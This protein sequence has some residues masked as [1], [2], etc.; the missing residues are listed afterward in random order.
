MGIVD[1]QCLVSS[2]RNVIKELCI[3]RV[4]DHASSHWIF[5]SLEV[6]LSPRLQKT[7]KWLTERFHGLPW[8][9]GEVPY[10]VMKP[11]LDAA[12]SC[13][14]FLLVKGV[15]K[16]NTLKYLLPFATIYNIE[17]LDCPPFRH[18]RSSTDEKCLYHNIK[19]NNFIC[20][21]S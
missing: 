4:D 11:I 10:D 18:L 3:V 9:Y 14:D 16:Y 20:S 12:T 13:F 2:N 21:K 15:Y 8:T 7:N 19:G 6:D 17:S 5:T 1:F